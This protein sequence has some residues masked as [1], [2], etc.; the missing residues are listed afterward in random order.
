VR[1]RLEKIVE[2][3]R[4]VLRPRPKAAEPPQQTPERWKEP[5]PVMRDR[6]G[7]THVLL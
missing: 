1:P 6:D 4:Q 7:H 3:L 5:L 2:S